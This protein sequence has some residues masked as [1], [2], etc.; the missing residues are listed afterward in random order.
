MLDLSLE[1]LEKGGPGSGN[2]DHAG[3]PGEVG[4]RVVK[5]AVMTRQKML[6][7][8]KLQ[9]EA[10]NCSHLNKAVYT[11]IQSMGDYILTSSVGRTFLK[12]ALQRRAGLISLSAII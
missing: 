7:T 5:V 11:R 1:A 9:L 3:R 2:F 12:K 6:E 4:G 8:R 10:G